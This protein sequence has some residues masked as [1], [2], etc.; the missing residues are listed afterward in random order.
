MKEPQYLAFEESLPGSTNNLQIFQNN[1]IKSFD[2]LNSN[3]S[4]FTILKG[5]FDLKDYLKSKNQAMKMSNFQ[6]SSNIII[7]HKQNH[8]KIIDM[9]KKN[10]LSEIGPSET[11][12]KSSLGLI[13]NDGSQ[14]VSNYENTLNERSRNSGYKTHK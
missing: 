5:S 12:S 3:L 10:D 6:P 1:A 7:K 2:N 11:Y 14:F 13:K 4:K 8:T 9:R